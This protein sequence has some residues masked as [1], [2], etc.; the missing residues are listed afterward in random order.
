[1]DSLRPSEE[2]RRAIFLSLSLILDDLL[3]FIFLDG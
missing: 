1:M 3:K 2:K